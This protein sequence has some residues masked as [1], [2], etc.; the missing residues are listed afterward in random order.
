MSA[1]PASLVA[2]AR[3]FA[4]W[5]VVDDDARGG[6]VVA[7]ANPKASRRAR[8]KREPDENHPKRKYTIDERLKHKG[9]DVERARMGG[10][11]D[12]DD[13][14]GAA[15]SSAAV[16][17][18]GDV[19]RGEDVCE[20]VAELAFRQ[21]AEGWPAQKTEAWAFARASALTASDVGRVLSGDGAKVLM[22]KQRTR[23]AE[24]ALERDRASSALVRE[25]TEAPVATGSSKKGRKGKGGGMSPAIYHGNEFESEALAHYEAVYSTKCLEFGLKIHDVHY[26]LGASPDGVHP[27]GRI[28]E[29]KC[30][31]SRPIIA[32][33]R[34]MEHYA[35]IQTLLE[36][37]DLEYC[38]FVQYKPAGR[39]K[40][41]SG[42]PDAPEFLCETIARDTEWWSTH[43]DELQTFAASLPSP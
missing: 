21:D 1:S 30:P 10:A 32:R 8:K 17:T 27:Q 40:G 18:S 16:S 43:F 9:V 12:R 5:R 39:G 3:R 37:F 22:R 33:R 29:I 4:Q 20:R 41:R 42:D 15:A 34:A 24:Q 38:D 25:V 14:D 36:V 2:L 6:G 28:V 11:R 13:G 7:R 19:P 35:Q 23:A 31:Y 26:W